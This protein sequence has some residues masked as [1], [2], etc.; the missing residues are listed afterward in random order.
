MTNEGGYQQ[1]NSQVLEVSTTDRKQC[2]ETAKT[3]LTSKAK[4][5]LD[6][7]VSSL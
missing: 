6:K 4:A 1:L 7:H 3:T 2:N 5:V